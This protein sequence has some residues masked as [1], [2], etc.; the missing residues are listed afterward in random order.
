MWKQREGGREEEV[1]GGEP[2]EGTVGR[3]GCG[4]LQ[5]EGEGRLL[6]YGICDGGGEG[7]IL[8]FAAAALAPLPHPFQGTRAVLAN[9]SSCIYYY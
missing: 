1:G 2:C 3:V 5:W 7:K 9:L 4:G 6:Q 8:V